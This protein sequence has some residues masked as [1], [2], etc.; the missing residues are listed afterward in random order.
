MSTLDLRGLDEYRAILGLLQRAAALA[1]RR[2]CDRWELAVEL[3][4][5]QLAGATITDL[6]ALLLDGVIEAAVETTSPKSKHRQFRKANSLAIPQGACFVISKQAV[7]SEATLM[8]SKI[9]LFTPTNQNQHPHWNK[10]S[11]ILSFGSEV[12]K[13]LR[14]PSTSQ[15]TILNAFEEEDWAHCIDDPLR[16][17]EGV[18]PKM[19][20]HSAIN[21]LNRGLVPVIHFHSN[22]NGRGICWRRNDVA[23]DSR[24]NRAKRRHGT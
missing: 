10:Q 15:L 2:N 23:G 24:S 11:Q 1:D 3:Q 7:N 16:P 8:P 19:R 14:R 22:G 6:R 17:K 18:D 12:I 5:L 13:Q 20:L 4:Q 21:N 9:L